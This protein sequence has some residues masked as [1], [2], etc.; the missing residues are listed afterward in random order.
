MLTGTTTLWVFIHKS[1]PLLCLPCF[2]LKDAVC[3]ISAGGGNLQMENELKKT[4]K[5]IC[6]FHSCPLWRLYLLVEEPNWK[7]CYSTRQLFNE[8]VKRRKVFWIYWRMPEFHWQW[9]QGW[10]V[11]V[12]LMLTGLQYN[13]ILVPYLKEMYYLKNE[14]S[15]GDSAILRITSKTLKMKHYES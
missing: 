3:V 4:Y 8:W 10:N 9:H 6:P 1:D 7:Q 2:H 5:P 11:L 14:I 15:L 12:T 13:S